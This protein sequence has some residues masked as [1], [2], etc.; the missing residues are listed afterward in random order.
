MDVLSHSVHC[1]IPTSSINARWSIV[2]GFGKT[3]SCNN[4]GFPMLLE[5]MV[6]C[7]LYSCLQTKL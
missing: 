6:L 3:M 4:C 1:V 2:T 5:D 7:V